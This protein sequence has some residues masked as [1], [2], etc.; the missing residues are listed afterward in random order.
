MRKVG[1]YERFEISTSSFVGVF[2]WMFYGLLLTAIAAIGLFLGAQNGWISADQYSMVLTVS[3]I[4]FFIYTFV[5]IFAMNVT[6]SKNAALVFYSIY[7]LLLGILLS[8]V[9]ILYDLGTVTYAFGAT[10]LV[11]GI[12]ALYGYFTKRDLTRFASI[13]TMIFFGV[14]I[15][16]LLN[17][18]C[19]FFL[20]P[21]T[22]GAINWVISYVVLAIII[23]YVAFDVQCLKNAAQNGMLANSLPIFLA[24]N[25]YTDFIAIFIRLVQ[26]IGAANSNN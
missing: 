14:I 22:Y 25:L 7:A 21:G 15:V 9:L 8:S 20:A 18:L 16:S 1:T 11:F 13:L 6:R 23:G 12:M 3:I 19:F 2:G 5:A 24:F 4:A 17:T 26:I 10:C